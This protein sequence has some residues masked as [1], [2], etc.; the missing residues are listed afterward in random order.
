MAQISPVL[1]MAQVSEDW[2]RPLFS[3]SAGTLED[4]VRLPFPRSIEKPFNGVTANTV[5]YF[6][7]L[8]KH[9]IDLSCSKGIFE[10]TEEKSSFWEGG[11]N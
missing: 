1:T 11:A 9:E 6:V 3:V 5:R 10:V 8:E 4:T 7:A 2:T